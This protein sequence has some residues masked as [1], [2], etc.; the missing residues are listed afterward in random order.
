MTH[1]NQ[2]QDPG[3]DDGFLP[4]IRDRDYRPGESFLLR[5]YP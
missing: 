2:L 5:Y 4:D 1:T 3:N